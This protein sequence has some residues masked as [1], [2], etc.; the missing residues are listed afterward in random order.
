MHSNQEILELMAMVN[1]QLAANLLKNS[2]QK[3]RAFTT[4]ATRMRHG[5]DT[6]TTEGNDSV[7]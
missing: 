5:T 1:P 6:I 4:H 7:E 2:S 3:K